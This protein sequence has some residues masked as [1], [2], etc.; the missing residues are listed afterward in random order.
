MGE[1]LGQGWADGAGATTYPGLKNMDDQL[2]RLS[3][4]LNVLDFGAVGDGTTDDAA[5]FRAA[6]SRGVALGVPVYVPGGDASGERTYQL[7][8]G[9]S[10]DAAYTSLSAVGRAKLSFSTLTGGATAIQ[11]YSSTPFEGWARNER[12][13]LEGFRITGNVSIPINATGILWGHATNTYNSEFSIRRVSVEGFQNNFRLM[14]NG[15]RLKI[16]DSSFQY[17]SFS[18]PPDLANA[19][20]NMIVE[21]CFIGNGDATELN[22]AHGFWYFKSCS[23]DNCK[24][25]LTGPS[26][27]TFESCHLENPGNTNVYRYLNVEHDEAS[28]WL[29]NST[30]ILNQPGAGDFTMAPFRVLDTNTYKGLTIANLSLFQFGYFT[31]WVT[32]GNAVLVAGNGRCE[33]LGGLKHWM[34]FSAYTISKALNGMYNGDAETA[35]NAG[36][37]SSG[38]GLLGPDTTVFKNGLVSFKMNVNTGQTLNVTQGVPV[39]PGKWIYWQHWENR[40]FSGVTYDR[41][42]QWV[43]AD[44]LNIGTTSYDQ[45]NATSS[46]WEIIHY[47]SQVVPPGAAR[48][49]IT[50]RLYN[51][52]QNN[53]A[54]Y[55][56]DIIV[57][58]V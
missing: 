47:S 4:Q 43:N 52:T 35:S 11:V 38:T 42:I 36:W 44:G 39:S 3:Q 7:N 55:L 53:Q 15:W 17:G 49:V 25:R 1:Y 58:V 45:Q 34:N 8:S 31:P 46:G 32:D 9:I 21:R 51:A 28:C 41:Y 33:V 6:L 54:V 40:Q 29:L 18:V 14:D 22:L 30:V 24:I 12:T 10:I 27:V 2:V 48:A 56:D 23:L 37:T 50:Y 16:L 5:A 19:G 13:A 20:E 57:N 26:A